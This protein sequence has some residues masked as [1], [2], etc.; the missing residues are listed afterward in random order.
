MEFSGI[1]QISN[2]SVAADADLI[3]VTKLRQ[4][5]SL[6]PGRSPPR[7]SLLLMLTSDTD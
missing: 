5:L 3:D 7:P 2:I 6:S 1:A 4:S